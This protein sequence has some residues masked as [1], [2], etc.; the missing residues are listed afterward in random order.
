MR[1]LLGA[2]ALRRSRLALSASASPNTDNLDDIDPIAGED[3]DSDVDLDV[4]LESTPAVGGQAP[5][6]QAQAPQ[7]QTPAGSSTDVGPRPQDSQLNPVMLQKCKA[8]R[9]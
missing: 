1:S 5:P 4:D 8:A 6:Q 2:A 9:H 7:E 3:L